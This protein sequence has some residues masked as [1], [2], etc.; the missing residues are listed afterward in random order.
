MVEAGVAADALAAQLAK[1]E[2]LEAESKKLTLEQNAAKATSLAST[3]AL[4]YFAL[5]DSL[6]KAEAAEVEA[7]QAKID[8]AYEEV[9]VAI[10]EKEKALEAAKN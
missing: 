7:I 5:N 10:E 8:A 3:T 6:E 9:C 2:K 4:R 1:T